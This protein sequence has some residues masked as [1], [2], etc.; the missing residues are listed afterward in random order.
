MDIFFMYLP[1][2]KYKLHWT[3][4]I[5]LPQETEQCSFVCTQHLV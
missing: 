2:L 1:N 4:E 3:L 5:D